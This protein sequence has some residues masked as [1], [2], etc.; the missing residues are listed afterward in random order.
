MGFRVEGSGGCPPSPPVTGRNASPFWGGSQKSPQKRLKK[1][2][3]ILEA[4]QNH[5]PETSPHLPPKRPT[6]FFSVAHMISRIDGFPIIFISFQVYPSRR[7]R[8]ST[9]A[10]LTRRT[11]TRMIDSGLVGTQGK[12]MSKSLSTLRLE[13]S[14]TQS[15]VSPSI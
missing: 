10:V 8:F 2:E 7:A 13:G 15:H 1:I 14:P 9:V 11:H 5:S 3:A 4:F 12:K 6:G